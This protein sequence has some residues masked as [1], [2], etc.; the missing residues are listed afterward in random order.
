ML[1][2]TRF[3]TPNTSRKHC[4]AIVQFSVFC[5]RRKLRLNSPINGPMS[6]A[7]HSLP[8]EIVAVV[9]LRLRI[10]D[11]HVLCEKLLLSAEWQT[12]KLCLS[13]DWQ[14]FWAVAN[15][16]IAPIC[17]LYVHHRRF[18]SDF[19]KH[20]KFR[21]TSD[22]NRLIIH[23]LINSYSLLGVP[24]PNYCQECREAYLFKLINY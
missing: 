9:G 6:I 13:A 11:P 10:L 2:C 21:F 4:A 18:L 22:R 19:F 3:P 8:I 20:H 5:D 17:L 14:S 1:L 23:Y 7:V 15:S 12:V 24:L 16:Q